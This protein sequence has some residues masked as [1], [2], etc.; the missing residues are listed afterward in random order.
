M[1]SDIRRRGHSIIEQQLYA[2]IRRGIVRGGDYDAACAG[3]VFNHNA[4]GGCGD[5]AEVN[6]VYAE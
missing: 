6:D 4:D 5:Y 3:K 1:L 2:V